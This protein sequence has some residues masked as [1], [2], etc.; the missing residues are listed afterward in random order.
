MDIT[1]II[2]YSL[3]SI[4]ILL[5][6]W[7]IRLEW[8]LRK[9]LGGRDARSLIKA[10][11]QIHKELENTD[12]FKR[13]TNSVLSDME[14]RLKKCIRGVKTVR[15]NPFKGTGSGGNQSFA[16]AFVNEDGDGVVISSLYSRERM[17]VF[18][19][20]LKRHQSE[21]ELSEEEQH[22]IKEAKRSVHE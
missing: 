15:F 7:I 9:L 19:K 3:A 16:T 13:Q 11:Q 17:S 10:V 12:V 4:C 20:P 1:S 22:V 8:R 6:L 5:V 21:F 18:S 14:R 2:I